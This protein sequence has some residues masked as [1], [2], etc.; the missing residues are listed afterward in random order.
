MK[1]PAIPAAI[2]RAAWAKNSGRCTAPGCTKKGV[3]LE[4]LDTW[5]VVQEHKLEN[6]EPRCADHKLAKDKTDIKVISKIRRLQGEAGQQARLRRRKSQGLGSKLQSGR[7]L[8]S[9]GFDKSRTKK[10]S[11]EVV[12]REVE[13]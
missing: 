13:G 3:I 1:R 7:K 6:L 11:G 10:F 5:F 12:L 9:A 2:K 4:H 8:C